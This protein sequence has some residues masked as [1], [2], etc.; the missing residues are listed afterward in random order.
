MSSAPGGSD[1][2]DFRTAVVED[3]RTVC[4]ALTGGTDMNDVPD[5]A[6]LPLT[7]PVDQAGFIVE[8][9]TFYCPDRMAAVTDDVYSKPVATKQREDCPTARA[10]EVT[11][12][13]GEQAGDDLIH[14]ASYSVEVRNTS[15]YTV[16]AQLQQRWFADGYPDEGAWGT[17]GDVTADPVV[18]IEAGDTFT[19]E[20][21]QS[22]VYRWE[23][24][25]V[26]VQPGE[27][28]F[29]RCGYQPGPGIAGT[30]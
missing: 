4:E 8:A 20:G 7:D 15:S 17:F 14:T 21:E 19:Y 10:L 25:D 12:S 9:V 5:V 2:A 26:R 6:G 28:V 3:A 23:R 30:D 22:G 16:R 13:I 24:T 1:I 18:T 11:A 29:F 27:F